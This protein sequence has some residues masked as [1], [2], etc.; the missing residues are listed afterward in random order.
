[1]FYLR[2]LDMLKVATYCASIKRASDLAA[3]FRRHRRA[4]DAD[5]FHAEKQFAAD[6]CDDLARSIGYVC[7]AH[8]NVYEQMAMDHPDVAHATA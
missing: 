6:L 1:M 2:N 8:A 4:E 3:E 7:D 5:K